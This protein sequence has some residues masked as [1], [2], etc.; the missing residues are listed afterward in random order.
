MSRPFPSKWWSSG[1]SGKQIWCPQQSVSYQVAFKRSTD[2]ELT[3]LREPHRSRVLV[4][5]GG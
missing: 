2:L 1:S 5:F 3:R 4:A